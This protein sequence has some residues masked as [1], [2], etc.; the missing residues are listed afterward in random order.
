MASPPIS[1]RIIS[2][3]PSH[4]EI[5]TVYRLWTS[6]KQELGEEITTADVRSELI[7]L[8]MRLYQFEVA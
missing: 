2:R 3:S 8:L 6:M 1:L 4:Q 5:V 7:P